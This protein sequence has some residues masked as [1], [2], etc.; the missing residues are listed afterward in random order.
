MQIEPTTF[1]MAQY[2]TFIGSMEG[3]IRQFKSRQAGGVINE[4][5]RYV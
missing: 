2:K 5:A 3:D 1:D 4:E